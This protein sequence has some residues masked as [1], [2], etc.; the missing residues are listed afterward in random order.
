MKNLGILYK[1]GKVVNHRSVTK[2]LLNPILRLFGYEIGSQFDEDTWEFVC[3]EFH[4][5]ERMNK[6]DYSNFNKHND[7]DYIIKKRRLI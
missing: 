2:I 7:F 3:L 5:T 4:K 1:D 6:L